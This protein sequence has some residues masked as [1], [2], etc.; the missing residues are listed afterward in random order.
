M[1]HCLVSFRVEPRIVRGGDENHLAGY[2]ALPF[3]ENP[4]RQSVGRHRPVAGVVLPKPGVYD[5]VFDTPR[6]ARAGA[7]TFRFWQNDASPPAVHVIGVRG[8]ALDVAVADGASGVDP[9]SLTVLV[10]RGDRPFVYAAA[11][12]RIPLS[13]IGRGRHSL[14][15][16]V[17]D[18]QETKN[19]EN[20]PQ[21]LLNTRVFAATFVR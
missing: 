2:A 5:I 21:V 10:D 17:S 11:R 4:Y 20:V 14:S 16:T 19:M 15:I 12:L 3:D 7:F 1:H 9:T 8:G 18:F 13:G 6:G